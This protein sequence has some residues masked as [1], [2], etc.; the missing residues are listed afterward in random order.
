MP[1]FPLSIPTPSG[2][3]GRPLSLEAIFAALSPHPKI[4]FLAD[5]AQ[6]LTSVFRRPDLGGGTN[7]VF[8]AWLLLR[9]QPKCLELPT[10]FRRSIAQPFDVD[11]PRQT[12]LDRSAD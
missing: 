11:A 10:P 8:G 2:L 5:K 4:P 9:I 12:T 6:R 1:G 7:G 3:C